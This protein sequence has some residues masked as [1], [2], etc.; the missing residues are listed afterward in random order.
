MI[1]NIPLPETDDPVDAPFWEG[2]RRG[3]LCIQTCLQCGRMRFPPRP[4][5][6]SCQSG[7]SHWQ[8]VSGRGRVWS[9]AA[10]SSPLLPAFE[11][12]TPYVVALVELEELPSLR[13]I[14]AVLLTAGG[15]VSGVS[16]ADVHI[17][18]A[19]NVDFRQYTDDVVMPC[20]VLA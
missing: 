19:V 20:W 7:A 1:E 8:R 16:A 17:G 2:T 9:F 5:C 3:E 14:G 11:K 18:A 4:M 12:M 6:P 10:P 15:E 13:M